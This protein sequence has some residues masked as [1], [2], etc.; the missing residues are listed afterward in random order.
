MRA[1][2][3]YFKTKI[4]YKIRRVN[5]HNYLFFW[6]PLLL[7]TAIIYK[8]LKYKSSKKSIVKYAQE[9]RGFL[10]L[11]ERQ[12]TIFLGCHHHHILGYPS[13]HILGFHSVHILRNRYLHILR[14][15]HLHILRN[16]YDLHSINMS[17]CYSIN[18]RYCTL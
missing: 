17:V 12:N 9:R 7:I 11:F 4:C 10:Y 1:Q 6:S 3:G 14:K 5:G 18:I 16:H 8:A 2:L 15:R 13:V